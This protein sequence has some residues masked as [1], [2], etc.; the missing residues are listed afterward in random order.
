[1]VALLYKFRRDL[2]MDAILLP[3][4]SY[5]LPTVEKIAYGLVIASGMRYT[6]EVQPYV[7]RLHSD[8]VAYN[9]YLDADSYSS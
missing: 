9:E 6:Q 8:V 7:G 2:F 5:T 4:R 3:V 1:M